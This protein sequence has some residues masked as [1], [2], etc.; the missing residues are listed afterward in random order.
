LWGQ[1]NAEGEQGDGKCAGETT[2]STLARHRFHSV[3]YA[4]TVPRQAHATHT[5]ERGPSG[6]SA[7]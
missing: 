1:G 2:R 4:A 6:R 7:R 5:N 3:D